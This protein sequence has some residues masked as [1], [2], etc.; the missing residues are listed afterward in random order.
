[1]LAEYDRRSHRPTPP[2]SPIADESDT[3]STY[4]SDV[5]IEEI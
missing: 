1:M 3:D 5:E 2:C 4:N